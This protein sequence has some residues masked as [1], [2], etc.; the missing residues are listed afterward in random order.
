MRRPMRKSLAQEAFPMTRIRMAWPAT[1][2]VVVVLLSGCDGHQATNH[3]AAAASGSMSGSI[4]ET[5]PSGGAATDGAA[6]ASAPAAGP[7]D[8]MEAMPSA[9]GAS[10][11]AAAAGTGGGTAPSDSDSQG[12]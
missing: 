7:G 1:L 11:A 8:A 6:S 5:L 12:D 10:S 9:A 4:A 2:A 3:K